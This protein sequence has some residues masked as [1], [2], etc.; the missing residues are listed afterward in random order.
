MG[1]LVVAVTAGMGGAIVAESALSWLGIGVPPP[2]EQALC[3]KTA[4]SS[5][6]RIRIC[7]RPQ[8]SPLA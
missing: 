2:N 5:G 1:P 6:A 8:P 3:S 7:S 4:S